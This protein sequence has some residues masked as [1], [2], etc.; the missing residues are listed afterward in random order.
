MTWLKR[1]AFFPILFYLWG[2]SYV[3]DNLVGLVVVQLQSCTCLNLTFLSGSSSFFENLCP[4]SMKMST[5]RGDQT[6]PETMSVST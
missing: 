2:Y 5:P 3:M 6:C 1:Y 4:S